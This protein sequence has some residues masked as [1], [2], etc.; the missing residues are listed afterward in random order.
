MG[1]AA[2]ACPAGGANN[3]IWC[4]LA[5]FVSRD[6]LQWWADGSER[7]GKER[8]SGLNL[9]RLHVHRLGY[10]VTVRDSRGILGDFV[11]G[12]SV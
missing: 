11:G 5:G 8:Y 9:S 6:V 10:L 7:T 12:G 4:R 2:I 3:W 1:L